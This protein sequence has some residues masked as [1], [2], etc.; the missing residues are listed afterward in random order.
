MMRPPGAA[1]RSTRRAFVRGT[2][3]AGG[4]VALAP[5]LAGCVAGNP[6]RARRWSG[7]FLTVATGGGALRQALYGALF[8]PF[9]RATGCR[10]TDVVLPARDLT[11]E[12]R[13]QVLVGQAEW[14]LVALDA[15]RLA[16]LSLDTPALFTRLGDLSLDRHALLPEPLRDS[17]IVIL[18]DTLALAA[19]PAPFGGRIPESWPAAWDRAAFPGPRHFPHDPVGL[20]EIALLADG[21]TPE[22]LYP[23]DFDRAFRSL[24]RL[25]TA[26]RAWWTAADAARDALALALADL[27]LARGGDLRT[28]IADGAAAAIAPPTAPA[29]PL[30]L[31]VP[32][33]ARNGD[34]A[35]DFLAYALRPATQAALRKQGYLPSIPSAPAT[36]ATPVTFPLDLP[37]WTEHGRDAL[38]R[39]EIWMGR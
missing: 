38:A 31:A 33:G 20:L 29:L 28:A 26:V 18:T 37:W 7:R 32:Q 17:G 5:L 8:E 25:R 24:E 22:Q 4:A 23:L 16:A 15:P 2:I 19:R 1:F 10:V 34:I 13:R 9:A 35:R 6:D 21:A 30:V 27:V 11:T 39:F 36:A 12:L 3:G 14:D